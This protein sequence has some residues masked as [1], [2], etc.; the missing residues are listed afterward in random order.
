MAQT[1]LIFLLGILA[2]AAA[3]AAWLVL[4]PGKYTPWER[5]QYG[6][7]Y[8]MA[9][10]LW[11]VQVYQQDPV[12]G[13]WMPSKGLIADIPDL[14]R[15]AKNSDSQPK[16]P[17]RGTCNHQGA[18]LV[19]N[20]RASVDPC[21]I[22]LAAGDRV[23][24]MVAGEYFKFPIVGSLLRSFQCIPTNRGGVDTASTKQAIELAKQGRFVGMF[25]EGRI[26][27]TEQA[28]IPVRPGAALVALRA[29]VPLVPMWITGAR[30][31]TSVISPLMMPSKVRVYL[32][33]PNTWGLE[34]LDLHDGRSDRQIADEWIGRVLGE[35]LEQATGR[36]EKIQLAGA[37]WLNNG[38][39]PTVSSI[40]SGTGQPDP[41]E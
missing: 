34:Q 27:R 33:K 17:I 25:P 15:N 39:D 37:K 7:V 20:H 19:A 3:T 28:W 26:N 41:E 5:I 38:V 1:A 2:L 13:S 16:P 23:H 10:Y 24:W 29:R 30:M 32:G 40:D 11:R 12:S 21:F 31:G 35:C 22:Q 36:C 18:V 8:L 4:K 6:P 9:R 14:I